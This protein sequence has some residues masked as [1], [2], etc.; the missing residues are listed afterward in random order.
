MVLCIAMCWSCNRLT[1]DF[2][3]AA[4]FQTVA[5]YWGNKPGYNPVA[6]KSMHWPGGRT[7]PTPNAPRCW[8]RYDNPACIKPGK[9]KLEFLK[10]TTVLKL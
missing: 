5:H 1:F 2:V 7:T 3:V 10:K 9:Y 6:G 4:L 8:F